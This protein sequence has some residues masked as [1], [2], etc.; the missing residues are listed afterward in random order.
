MCYS[1]V[2]SR[3]WKSRSKSG[4]QLLLDFCCKSRHWSQL[5][6]TF[7]RL[8]P[9]VTRLQRGGVVVT[10]PQDL[11]CAQYRSIIRHAR[12][13]LTIP[14]YKQSSTAIYIMNG[15]YSKNYFLKKHVTNNFY[16]LFCLLYTYQSRPRKKVFDLLHFT[17]L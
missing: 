10:L 14:T 3:L 16:F 17:H 7:S 11:Q 1:F 8:N 12:V 13:H 6:L 15:T 4:T 9:T 2:K 5:Y